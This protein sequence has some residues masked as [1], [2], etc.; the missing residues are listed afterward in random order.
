MR[1]LWIKIGDNL[2]L[3][4]SSDL[5]VTPAPNAG[6]VVTEQFLSSGSFD[7]PLLRPYIGNSTTMHVLYE[8]QARP[9]LRDRIKACAFIRLK[10]RNI[11]KVGDFPAPYARQTIAYWAPE[12]GCNAK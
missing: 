9:I 4:N 10:S 5:F 1:F 7:V 6:K 3:V 8:Q 12:G 11:A 2:S